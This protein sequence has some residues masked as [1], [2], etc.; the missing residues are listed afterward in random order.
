MV[1]TLESLQEVTVASLT[2]LCPPMKKTA[3][4][5]A[6]ALVGWALCGATMKLGL[7]LA[8]E[9]TALTLHAVVAPVFFALISLLYFRRFHFTRPLVTASIFVGV[10][11]F[12]DVFVIAP[13][14]EKSFEMFVS[15]TGTWLPFVLIF[16]STWLTGVVVMFRS[17]EAGPTTR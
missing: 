11:V 8:S 1:R 12:M 6:H 13:F 15:F 4:I 17:G 14:V 10:V 3:I 9:N 5:L 7:A 16:A 2:T